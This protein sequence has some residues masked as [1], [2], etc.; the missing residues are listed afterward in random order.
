[1][2]KTLLIIPLFLAALANHGQAQL[3]QVIA[4]S[5]GSGQGGGTSLAWTLGEPVISN[6]STNTLMMT[7]GFH[8][9]DLMV[10]ALRTV[11]GLPFTIE[12]YPNP[13]SDFIKVQLNGVGFHDF[14]YLLFDATG[15]LLHH[16]QPVSAIT[17]IDMGTRAAGLYLLKT[18]Q[19][20]R[21]IKTFEIIKH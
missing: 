9:P 2:K 10:T 14:K 18:M 6:L 8:Q 1:M 16:I 12:A 7:S 4:T 15:R 3:L 20:G 13:A 21:E 5:G 19:A 17:T 11:D